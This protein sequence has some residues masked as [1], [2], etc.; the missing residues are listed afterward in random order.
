MQYYTQYINNKP[1]YEMAGIYADEAI[2]GTSTRK[3]DGFNRMIEDCDNGKIDY[4]ITKSISR[5]ARNTQDCLKYSRH[6][7]SLGI[8]IYFEKEN[9]NTLDAS[10]ELLFTILSSLAQEE[11]RNISE[12]SKWGIRHGFKN[13]KPL[14]NTTSFM[15]YDKDENGKLVINKEQAK[16]VRRIYTRFLEGAPIALIC[17]ELR[18]DK[19]RGIN[20][21]TWACAVVRAMLE[22]EKHCGD[23]LMQKTYCEDYLSKKQVKNYG[24]V[25]QY[26]VE[27]DHEAIIPKDEWLAVQ[28]ELQRRE[29]YR[30]E[31]G[32]LKYYSGL[33]GFSRK[34]VCGCCGKIYTRRNADTNGN[35]KWFCEG[36]KNP[37]K[38]SCKGPLVEEERLNKA[39][40][41]AWNT[42]VQEKDPN[43]LK[44]DEQIVEGDPL[45]RLRAR[46]MKMMVEEG[47]ISEVVPEHVMLVLERIVVHSKEHFEVRF[48][49]G[50]V[51]NVCVG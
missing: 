50:T 43:I 40:I 8:G 6:L 41:I 46:Q 51:K 44:W 39:F 14:I 47:N 17:R 10:G 28:L 48:L 32:F 30:N 23:L 37:S 21:G 18:D 13:G 11:S 2:T 35:K 20:N 26:F 31:V 9:I 29:K 7:K 25:D 15:G 36:K 24:E 19:V 16:I 45:Q 4:V 5:F 12:N 34:V 49:D 27:N 33:G 22:N 1:E 3:R 42:I 38:D